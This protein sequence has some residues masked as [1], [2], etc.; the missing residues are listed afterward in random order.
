[1]AVD[2]Y[3]AARS[4]DLAGLRFYATGGGALDAR[5]PGQFQRTPLH[6]AIESGQAAAARLLI[7]LGADV[8]A[9]DY[10]DARPLHYAAG[11]GLL[12]IV[13]LL[14]DR[15]AEPGA[16]NVFGETALHSLAAGGGLAPEDDQVRIAQRLVAAS[17]PVDATGN[18]GRTPL[19]YA[20]ARGKAGVAAALLEAGADPARRAG[21]ELGSPAEVASGAVTSLLRRG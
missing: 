7:E 11:M 3:Q 6:V 18:A 10:R 8:H 2:P 21:G 5:R 20:A 13:E 19:W 14:L 15:G 17:V 4:G 16:L 1:M 9:A 12:A